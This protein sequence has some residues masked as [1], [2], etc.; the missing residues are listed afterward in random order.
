MNNSDSTA[1]RQSA[2]DLAAVAVIK[3]AM[4]QGAMEEI[5]APH[6]RVLWADVKDLRDLRD[7]L[8]Q[9]EAGLV[10]E[11]LLAK[12]RF[13]HT[14][15]QIERALAG[16]FGPIDDEL[17]DAVER[18][19]ARRA[20]VAVAIGDCDGALRENHDDQRRVAV[21]LEKLFALARERARDAA[22]QAGCCAAIRMRGRLAAR[23]PPSRARARARRRPS[24][25]A[26]ARSDTDDGEPPSA[27][28]LAAVGGAS[29]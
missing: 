27:L 11:R 15:S 26:R 25:R 19:Q 17:L 18:H 8:V 28:H 24:T 21:E 29:W 1:L 22:M 10:G 14:S 4:A 16:G 5:D 6:L 3:R 13:D 20:L 9:Q 2:A 23:R 12:Q 7:R